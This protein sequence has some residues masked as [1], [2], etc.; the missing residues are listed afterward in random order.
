MKKLIFVVATV[1]F[2]FGCESSKIQWAQP[3]TSEEMVGDIQTNA[4]EIKSD[5]VAS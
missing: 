2:I 4:E 5:N 1:F 3:P